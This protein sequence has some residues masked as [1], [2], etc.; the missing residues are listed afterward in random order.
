LEGRIK[1]F[2]L[3]LLKPTTNETGFLSSQRGKTEGELVQNKGLS[4]SLSTHSSID[5]R[6]FIGFSSLYFYKTLRIRLFMYSATM[7]AGREYPICLY[8]SRQTSFPFFLGWEVL[9]TQ[10][11]PRHEM[12]MQ[13]KIWKE[14]RVSRRKN[15]LGWRYILKI[16]TRNAAGTRQNR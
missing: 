4:E 14:I 12:N 11:Q 5:D 8:F 7:A 16:E 10:S 15:G 3:L 6:L 2:L 9:K 13:K 1:Y